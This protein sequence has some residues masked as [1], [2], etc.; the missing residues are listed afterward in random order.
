MRLPNTLKKPAATQAPG[1]RP[2]LDLFSARTADDLFLRFLEEY[3][4]DF[5]IRR[6]K[7]DLSETP[8]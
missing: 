5:T 8:P 1:C 7:K 6:I 4:T 2:G 3:L